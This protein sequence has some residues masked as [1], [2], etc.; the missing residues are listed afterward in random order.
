MSSC[1][2]VFRSIEQWKG[3]LITLPDGIFFEMMRSVLGNVASP[4]N[5]QR[6]LDELGVFLSRADV[7]KIVAAYISR[8]DHKIIAAIAVLGCPPESDVESFFSGE[9]SFSEVHSIILNLEERLIV[10]RIKK[11]DG[12][13]SLSLNPLFKKILLPFTTNKNILF[14]NI[15]IKSKNILSATKNETIDLKFA[16]FFALIINETDFFTTNGTLKRNISSKLTKLFSA[17]DSELIVYALFNLGLLQNSG[18]INDNKDKLEDFLL[19][20]LMERLVYISTGIYLRLEEP[21]QREYQDDNPRLLEIASVIH[22]FIQFF[23]KNNMFEGCVF[24]KK[25]A[26]KRFFKITTLEAAQSPQSQ[27]GQSKVNSAKK[28]IDFDSLISALEITGLI[29]NDGGHYSFREIKDT[30]AKTT[31]KTPSIAFDSAYTFFIMPEI[32]FEKIVMLSKF[33]EITYDTGKAKFVLTRASVTNAF[34]NGINCN[35]IIETLKELSLGRVNGNIHVMLKDWEKRYTDV[36]F[37]EGLT[38]VLSPEMCFLAQTE[39]FKPLIM[40]NP[41]KGVYI[42][43]LNDKKK[44]IAALKKAGI[45]NAAEPLNMNKIISGTGAKKQKSQ[46]NFF[47]ELKNSKNI[48]KTTIPEL[49]KTEDKSV[50]YKDKF[51]DILKTMN[52]RQNEREELQER[53]ERGL[54]ISETQLKSSALRYEKL[55]ADSMDYVGKLSITKQAISAK[56]ILE[57]FFQNDA[58]ENVHFTGYPKSLEKTD[59]G[60]LLSLH[61]IEKKE[62]IKVSIG[63]IQSLRRIK[64][65]IF[66]V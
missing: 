24:D 46:E 20:S 43:N 17:K 64:Q 42:T 23:L 36:C 11:A 10:Y 47:P 55:K 22:A 50:F 48:I 9:L 7:Q 25:T 27:T 29:I 28:D 35:E 30:P 4:F 39:T 61:L 63:K 49:S 58:G 31:Q 59:K 34:N 14:P 41:A 60:M 57:L 45:E 32:S 44:V 19:L 65:S 66:S 6:L 18:S 38:V 8:D 40:S 54:I 37:Y 53:I 62:T 13:L 26:L 5:K 15:L 52:I 3:S 2:S 56:E 33:C 16:L 51:R 12:S 1:D 21:L